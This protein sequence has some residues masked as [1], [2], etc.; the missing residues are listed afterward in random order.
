MEGVMRQPHPSGPK[1]A[2]QSGY[3]RAACSKVKQAIKI[4]KMPS[5][6]GEIGAVKK[7]FI[8]FRT[9]RISIEF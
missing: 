2:C 6:F 3:Q 1:K 5:G 9:D 7:T 4:L 8:L